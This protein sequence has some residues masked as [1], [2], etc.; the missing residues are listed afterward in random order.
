MVSTGVIQLLTVGEYSNAAAHGER[1]AGWLR[2]HG[3]S[4][5]R[6][7]S[8]SLAT[9]QSSSFIH[10]WKAAVFNRRRVASTATGSGGGR[11]G[12]SC[13]NKYRCSA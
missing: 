13:V 11:L 2:G 4:N 7:W 5:A 10:S 3:E 6:W 9:S 1:S 12:S 8:T